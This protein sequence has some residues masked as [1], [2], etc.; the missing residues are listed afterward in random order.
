[1]RECFGIL[2]LSIKLDAHQQRAGTSLT[3]RRGSGNLEGPRYHFVGWKSVGETP[4][5][6]QDPAAVC[7]WDK[8]GIREQG[9]AVTS[10]EATASPPQ[11][12]VCPLKIPRKLV[13]FWHII[14]LCD[15]VPVY[16]KHRLFPKS[17][18]ARCKHLHL[19]SQP[20]THWLQVIFPFPAATQPPPAQD[21]RACC[22]FCI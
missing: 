13:F 10:P 2:S 9:P 1:M 20:F 12:R 21:I 6:Q 17:F 19:M 4:R 14:F 18:L 7:C 22:R 11:A 5:A 3:C 8:Q 16:Q 15:D